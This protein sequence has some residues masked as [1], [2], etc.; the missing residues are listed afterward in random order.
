MLQARQGSA[1]RV[2]DLT[3][4]QLQRTALYT[5][6]NQSL[7]R[8]FVGMDPVT[9]E[10]KRCIQRKHHPLEPRKGGHMRLS[11][12]AITTLWGP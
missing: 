4:V 7:E 8:S 1:V 6:I 2:K 3:I 12:N 10:V 11:T 5:F 9:S